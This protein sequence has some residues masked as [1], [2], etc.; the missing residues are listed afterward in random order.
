MASGLRAPVR[1]GTDLFFIFFISCISVSE[2]TGTSFLL[3]SNPALLE[4]VRFSGFHS[5][6]IGIKKKTL[7]ATIN[8]LKT[9]NGNFHNGLV[10]AIKELAM[11]KIP[12]P[13]PIQIGSITI[14]EKVF[15]SG[16]MRIN[17]YQSNI[18]K[19]KIK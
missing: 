4:G 11:V 19:I 15:G 13:T 1:T 2:R 12:T 10:F 8:E 14:L 9:K 3:K 17:A 18:G 6:K 5:G 7:T 16:I